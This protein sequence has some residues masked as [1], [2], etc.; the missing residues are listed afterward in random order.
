MEI[1]RNPAATPLKGQPTRITP[2]QLDDLT[3]RWLRPLTSVTYLS[4]LLRILRLAALM[5]LE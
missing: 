4:K 2:Q 1:K 3:L 5:Q